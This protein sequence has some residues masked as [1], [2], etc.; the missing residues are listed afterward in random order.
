MSCA[1][2]NL[3]AEILVQTFLYLDEPNSLSF[4]NKNLYSIGNA[5]TV[6]AECLLRQ[7]GLS[8][9]L[10]KKAISKYTYGWADALLI[11]VDKGATI[12]IGK[13]ASTFFSFLVL[14]LNLHL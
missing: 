2:E 9:C 8:L 6:Q 13:K 12:R 14:N 1:L 4:T 5:V 3:P 11:L 10:S 7:Y